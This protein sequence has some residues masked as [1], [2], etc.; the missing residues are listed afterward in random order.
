[1][2]RQTSRE[3]MIERSRAAVV[4]RGC[5]LASLSHP[6]TILVGQNDA[7]GWRLSCA[8]NRLCSAI[9]NNFAHFPARTILGVSLSA[10]SRETPRD[11]PNIAYSE[12]FSS[13]LH[14]ASAGSRAHSALFAMTCNHGIM[15]TLHTLH[16][17]QQSYHNNVAQRCI[18][19]EYDNIMEKRKQV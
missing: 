7:C 15:V 5:D 9:G 8:G 6:H 1:M 4:L 2:L 3:S 12:Q 13:S 11:E 17:T 10:F 18:W 19:R 16:E 14:E